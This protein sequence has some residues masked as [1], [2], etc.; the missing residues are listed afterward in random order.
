MTYEE[1]E[2]SEER[3]IRMLPDDE[4]SVRYCKKWGIVGEYAC[5]RYAFCDDDGNE[6]NLSL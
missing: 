3:L 2:N 4:P 6:V 1:F 5:G